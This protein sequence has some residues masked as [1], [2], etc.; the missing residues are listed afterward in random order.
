MTSQ[1]ESQRRF[2]EDKLQF[3]EDV[4]HERLEEL[5]RT[6]KLLKEHAQQLQTT[7]EALSKDKQQHE[8]RAQTKTTKLQH[9]FEEERLMN[10]QLRQNQTYF[11]DEMHK[12]KQEF[13]S[14]MK[15]KNQVSDARCCRES[16]RHRP[17]IV[18]L[19][20]LS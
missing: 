3:V 19:S 12:L 14:A 13:E 16:R 7:V 2:F 9:N 18:T 5:E 10:D 17:G 4:T 1:L 20:Q 6:N 15:M 8:K 11:Q